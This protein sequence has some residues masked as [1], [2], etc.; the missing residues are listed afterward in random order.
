MKRR[1][2]VD[3]VGVRLRIAVG[4]D[5][6]TPYVEV[7]LGGHR[8]TVTPAGARALI[9]GL[10]D[11]VAQAERF[12]ADQDARKGPVP[13]PDLR[14]A[15]DLTIEMEGVIHDG[16][17]F[18]LVEVIA[19]RIA[20]LLTREGADVYGWTCGVDVGVAERAA[21]EERSETTSGRL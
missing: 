17:Q 2:P 16:D 10:Y 11:A 13:L 15:T 21:V 4:E 7:D 1:P 9:E 20:A 6:A 18:E 8:A 19:A 12:E 3:K 5:R 14:H